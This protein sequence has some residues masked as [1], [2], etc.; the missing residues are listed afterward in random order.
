MHRLLESRLRESF[1]I[2]NQMKPYGDRLRFRLAHFD[3]AD[4]GN[5]LRL[6][7]A[8]REMTD[9]L[10]KKKIPEEQ[11][12]RAVA[13]ALDIAADYQLEAL[14]LDRCLRDLSRSRACLRRLIKQLER[15][16]QEIS[17]LPPLAKGQLNKIVTERDWPNFDTETY[18]ELIVAMTDALSESS[19]ACTVEKVLAAIN[20]KIGSGTHPAV[21]QI[22]RTARPALIELW[23]TIPAE[24]RT[25]V[26]ANLRNWAPP[27]RRAAIEFV[28]RLGALLEK[29]WPQ[30]NHGRRLSII[31]RLGQRLARTWHAVGLNVVSGRSRSP[32]TFQRFTELALIGVVGGDTRLSN[33]QVTNLKSRIRRERDSKSKSLKQLRL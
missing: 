1:T 22:V 12:Q 31:G 11:A 26:E 13:E 6:E 23:E 17:K 33:R 27:K 3:L 18:N 2:A 29:F 24:T 20:E 4:Q 8:R 15:L 16:N 28:D 21:V 19:P 7:N 10:I 25:Q 30:L 9:I 5:K 32:G 14:R